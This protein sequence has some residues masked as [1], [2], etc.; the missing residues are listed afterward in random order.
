MPA[1]DV[2]RR[3]A[4]PLTVLRPDTETPD[5]GYVTRTG[6]AVSGVT[7]HMQ[8]LSDKEQRF[9]PEG[10]NTLEWWNVWSQQE[11]QEGDQVDDGSAPTVT[12]AKVKYWKEGLYWHAQ[13]TLVTDGTALALPQAFADAFAPAYR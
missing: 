8:P 4:I 10:M 7:G 1:H 6:V 5:H 12:V 11:I 9:V 3:R 13:G 2:I